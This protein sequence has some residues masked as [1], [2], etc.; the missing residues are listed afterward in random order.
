MTFVRKAVS[1]ALLGVLGLAAACGGTGP[2]GLSDPSPASSAWVNGSRQRLAASRGAFAL[3]WSQRV[4]PPFGDAYVP[5]E[6]S[7]PAVDGERDRIYVGSTVGTLWAL[8]G[9]GRRV[10]RYEA[11]ASLEA[12]PVLD[13]EKQEVY[14]VS[15]DGVVHALRARSGRLRWKNDS[16]V[17]ATRIPVL[18]VDDALYVVSETDQVAALS[19][20]TGE[21]LWRYKRAPTDGYHLGGHAALLLAHDHLFAAFSDGTVAALDPTDGRPIWE[22]ETALDFPPGEVGT[23]QRFSD[24]DTTPVLVDRTLYVASFSGGLYGLELGSGTVASHQPEQL[25]ITAI[26]RIESDLLLSKANGTLERVQLDG[27]TVWKRRISRGTAAAVVVQGDLIYVSESRGGFVACSA[28][29]GAELSRI[30]SGF[31]F[32]GP[33]AFSGGRGAVLSNGGTLYA[34]GTPAAN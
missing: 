19:R 20:E 3:R 24:V 13:H 25:G 23:G 9:N 18:L 21:I 17:G 2:V 6:F 29:T 31:G 27:T 28:T 5:V 34:F 11:G 22:R 10:Y 7:A 26:H 12:G 16:G 1:V 33:A 15:E 32:S 4:V 30:E 8:H 14:L